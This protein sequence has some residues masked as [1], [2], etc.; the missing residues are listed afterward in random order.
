MVA[1]NI[2]KMCIQI[3]YDHRIILVT[4]WLIQ[5]TSLV[6]V[7]IL[8]TGSK[9]EVHQLNKLLKLCTY[10]VLNKHTHAEKYRIYPGKIIQCMKYV[11]GDFPAKTP[12]FY[13]KDKPILRTLDC[14][15]LTVLITDI[16]LYIETASF[17]RNITTAVP[18]MQY[19]SDC[20][21]VK[22]FFHEIKPHF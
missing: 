5:Y 6:C 9:R 13:T 21:N 12:R 8:Y 19:L 7:I 15:P 18:N 10:C 16:L 3:I 20:S 14:S 11:C 4:I 22:Y 2:L 1:V 17:N